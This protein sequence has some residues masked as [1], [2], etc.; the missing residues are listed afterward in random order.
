MKKTIYLLNQLSSAKLSPISRRTK[1]SSLLL[2]ATYVLILMLA[3]NAF[4][5]A[6]TYIHPNQA[7]Q[8]G[9]NTTSPGVGNQVVTSTY[10]GKTTSTGAQGVI[11]VSNKDGTHKFG[12]AD[13]NGYPSD[14]S[15][16]FYTTP[17]QASDGKVYGSTYVGG[18][19]NIGAVYKYEAGSACQKSL[20]YSN[21]AGASSG[22]NFANVNEL[23]DGK[24]YAV[25]SYGTGGY[26]GVVKMD[27]DGSNV[28][29]LHVFKYSTDTATPYTVGA[30][31]NAGIAVPVGARYDGAYPYGEGADGKVYGTTYA[32]GYGNF[33][34]V[35]RMDKD[36]SNYEIIQLLYNSYRVMNNATSTIPATAVYGPRNPY[37][38]VAQGQDGRIYLLTYTGGTGNVGG[39]WS[40]NANGTDTRILHSGVSADGTYPYRGPTIINGAVY[41]TFSYGGTNNNG[42]VFK[43]DLTT[44]SYSKLH[45]FS[46]TTDGYLPWAGVSYDGTSLYGTCIAGGG[47]GVIGTLW[48]IKPDGSDFQVLHRFKNDPGG[49]CGDP[50]LAPLLAYYPSAERVTFANISASCSQTCPDEAPVINSITPAEQQVCVGTT[51][52]AIT[53]SA[54]G[55]GTLTYQWYSNTT[56]SNSGGTLISGATTNTYT[57]P[58]SAAGD[59]YYY[60]VVT[61]DGGS[62]TSNAVRVTTSSGASCCNAGTTAPVVN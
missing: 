5:N 27:K 46:N 55:T 61:G 47:A 53:V 59:M 26:G 39:L 36:G 18:A 62:T 60:V 45:S 21:S 17:H 4:I 57:P 58:A 10:Y 51:A 48:K 14:G 40:F 35:W 1:S 30:L 9:G 11:F 7:G 2:K 43:Y 49:S 3:H 8:R 54:T 6:Q 22:G 50:Q 52:T 34:T 19:N 13:F 33:G 44:N 20:I 23:S 42:V 41:G 37:G 29:V 25:M 24:I 28:Q 16:P 56:D 31:A 38:N 12:V 32:G 15:Y